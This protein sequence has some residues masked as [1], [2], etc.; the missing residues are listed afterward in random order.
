M[1]SWSPGSHIGSYEILNLLGRGGMGAV[2]RVRH[3]IT[4]RIE[5]IKVIGSASGS[6]EERKERFHREVR[7]LRGKAILSTD[8]HRAL[9]CWWR[10]KRN[11]RIRF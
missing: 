8:L 6:S 1:T 4:H 9:E 7:T 2:Y 11:K 10:I 5:A 3:L